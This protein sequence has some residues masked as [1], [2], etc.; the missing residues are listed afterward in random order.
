MIDEFGRQSGKDAQD[1]HVRPERA[2]QLVGEQGFTGIVPV[3]LYQGNGFGQ[4]LDTRLQF[5]LLPAVFQPQTAFI[6]SVQVL[7]GNGYGV[8]VGGSGITGK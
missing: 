6:V 7:T 8:R 4:Q 1:F 2:V 3:F 5:V